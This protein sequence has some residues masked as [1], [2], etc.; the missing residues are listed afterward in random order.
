MSRNLSAL[1][2]RVTSTVIEDRD[3]LVVDLEAT[4][5]QRGFPRGQMEII[6]IGAV[7]VDGRT[8]DPKREFQTFVRPIRVPRLTRFCTELTSIA[9]ADVDSAP[10]F[11]DALAALEAFVGGEPVRFGSW[12][13]YDRGQFEQDA[14]LHHLRLPDCLSDHIDL[15]AAFAESQGIKRCGMKGALRRVGLPLAGTHHRG[16]DDARNIA[17]LLPWCLG[18]R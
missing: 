7:L 6:E 2:D 8:L 3:L 16:I 5:D 1:I 9:Q 11:G 12:G 10:F 18:R 15:K 14:R 13:A 17:A 4:C